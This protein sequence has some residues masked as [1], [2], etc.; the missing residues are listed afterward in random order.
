MIAVIDTS[1][2]VKWIF[3]DPKREPGV[4]H[5][6]TLLQAVADGEV[7][8]LQPPHWLAE[9][10][11]VVTRLDAGLAGE[12]LDL[13]HAMELPTAEDVEVYQRAAAIAAELDHHV[14][15]TLYHAVALERG[16][17]LV[18]ADRRYVRKAT[19]LGRVVPLESWETVCV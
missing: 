13:L 19:S 10:A 7:E 6:L 5:A 17:T 14:F 18:S 1:V 4:G 11:A 9:V 12:A 2:A 16:A 3:P 15:D 8:P